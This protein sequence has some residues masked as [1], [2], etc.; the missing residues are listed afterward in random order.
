M[1]LKDK[2]KEQYCD[3]DRCKGAGSK[4]CVMCTFC[5]TKLCK[6]CAGTGLTCLQCRKYGCMSCR[7]PVDAD[8]CNYCMAGEDYY[9]K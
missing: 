7:S 1:S 2:K 3:S 6:T 4:K 5:G 9:T 8:H